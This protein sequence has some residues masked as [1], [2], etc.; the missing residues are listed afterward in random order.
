MCTVYASP[1]GGMAAVDGRD[2]RT[3]QLQT[4]VN[5][6]EPGDIVQLLPGR[7]TQPVVMGESGEPGKPIILRGQPD[8]SATLD[9]QQDRAVALNDFKPM[10]DDFAFIQVQSANWI[11][12]EHLSFENCWPS[13]VFIRGSKNVTIR[14]SKIVGGRFGVYARNRLRPER[15]AQ[16]IL[17]ENVNWVQDPD[18][19]MWE[20]RTTWIDVKQEEATN[21]DARYFN[22]ALF[23]SYDIKGQVT[24]R[25][26][27]V[28]HA[29]NVFRMD[30]KNSQ[31]ERGRNADVRFERNNICYIRDNVIEPEKIAERWWV[32]D[33]CFFNV[34]AA[35]SLD[36][37]NGQYW[38]F[39]NNRL[40][41]VQKPGLKWQPN[42]GG[43]IFKFHKNPP[44]PNKAFYVLYNSIQT[45]TAYTKKGET[46]HWTHA[47]NAIGI[48][49]K[50]PD[51]DADR[52]MFSPKFKWHKTN[53]FSNDICDHSDFPNDLGVEGI[54]VSG[55]KGA[56][57]TFA[58]PTFG[59]TENSTLGGWDG[60]LVLSPDSLGAASSSAQQIE[61]PDGSMHPI[62]GGRDIG[63]QPLGDIKLP[64][65]LT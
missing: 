31:L 50:G 22:G 15:L 40:L 28:S 14:D 64:V 18:H 19:D 44:F 16:N 48:C 56:P 13:A 60:E 17:L 26:C 53:D 29:F 36:G 9:G 21:N 25:K 45:R 2:V 35:F 6:V 8:F 46:R 42:R 43:K 57:A 54:K 12:L 4:A 38:Y 23:G 39:I 11:V 58:P 3:Y 10:D 62:P 32:L 49:I 61:L 34:H 37:V 47:N 51:C 63:A 7:Y 59:S 1:D 52:K 27:D 20:G 55:F 24:V 65:R 41:N 5:R 30:A 33:N